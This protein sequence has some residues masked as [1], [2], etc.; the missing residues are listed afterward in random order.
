MSE[1]AAFEVLRRIDV[2]CL[3]DQKG[4]R[5]RLPDVLTIPSD[6]RTTPKETSR[7]GQSMRK[8]D[9]ASAKRIAC[10]RM[11][12]AAAAVCSTSAAFCCVV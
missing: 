5:T 3:E 12:S 8:I 10:S 1:W 9:I 4:A 7:Q 6:L 2:D 11:L